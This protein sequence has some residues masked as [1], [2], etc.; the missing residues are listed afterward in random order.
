M[1]TNEH[2]VPSVCL[3]LI[4]LDRSFYSMDTITIIPMFKVRNLNNFPNVIL[5]VSSSS[6]IKIQ[7]T[8][9]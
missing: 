1:L 8:L 3:V 6:R 2:Q 7:T 9:L 5:L 4:T